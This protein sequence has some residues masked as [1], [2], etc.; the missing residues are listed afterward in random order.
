MELIIIIGVVWLI[1]GVVWLILSVFNTISKDRPNQSDSNTNTPPRRHTPPPSRPI[2]RPIKK[3]SDQTF[4][5]SARSSVSNKISFKS[6]PSSEAGSNSLATVELD[7]LHDAFTGAPLDKALGL[8]Q[9]QTCKVYYHTESLQVLR[10]ANDSKCASCQSTNIISVVAGGKATGGKD[11]TP[12][13]VTLENYKQFEGTVVTFEGLV[14]RVNESRR[15]NDFA[16]MFEAKSWSSG[17][18]LVFFREEGVRKVGGKPYITQLLRKTVK[19]RG[20]LV[21]HPECGYEII[22]SEKSMILDVK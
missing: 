4:R 7:G 13:V 2:S 12:N 3:Q 14:H 17:F 11:Y 21:K 15:G 10:E 18:K 22:V 5:P 6:A 9:C 16:V 1:L 19:I 20:L 8:Y